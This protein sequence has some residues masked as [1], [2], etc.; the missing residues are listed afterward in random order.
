MKNRNKMDCDDCRCV[1]GRLVIDNVSS[2]SGARA[3]DHVRWDIIHFNPAT[4][5]PTFSAGGVAFRFSQESQYSD[6]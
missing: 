1:V 6:D 5:P 4:T 3:S 2:P